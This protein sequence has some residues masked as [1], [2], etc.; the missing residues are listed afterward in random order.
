MKKSELFYVV[1]GKTIGLVIGLI[2]SIII[3]CR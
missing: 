3:I 1:L 2:A